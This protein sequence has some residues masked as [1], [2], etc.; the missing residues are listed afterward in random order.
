MENTFEIVKGDRHPVL[1][2]AYTDGEGNPLPLTGWTVKLYIGKA[3]L[4]VK[5]AVVI[6]EIGGTYKFEWDETDHDTAGDFTA[7]IKMIDGQN[8]PL[9]FPRFTV[10][11]RD[12]I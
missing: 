9:T 11:V 7:A 1:Y 12:S 8:K 2:G 4:L 6:D 10:K 5:E 3:A